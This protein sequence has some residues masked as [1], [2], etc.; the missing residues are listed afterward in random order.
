MSVVR[1]PFS[2]ISRTD[3]NDSAAQTNLVRLSDADRVSDELDSLERPS[4]KLDRA[5][6][7]RALHLERQDRAVG[8]HL[9]VGELMAGMRLERRVVHARDSGVLGK[10]V[11]QDRRGL[12][13]LTLPE[14]ERSKPSR[15]EE[16]AQRPCRAPSNRT[17]HPWFDRWRTW[18]FPASAGSLRK[19]A[20]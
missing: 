17:S 19:R 18:C 7:R 14:C 10:S 5:P 20:R 8:V 1:H 2:G 12:T 3:T 6:G 13:R 9:L 11:R 15:D 4:S 16:C